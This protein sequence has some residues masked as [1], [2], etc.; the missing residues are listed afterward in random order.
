MKQFSVSASQIN[1]QSILLEKIEI[2]GAKAT[3]F[4]GTRQVNATTLDRQVRLARPGAIA[5]QSGGKPL[6]TTALSIHA[7]SMRQS[8]GGCWFTRDGMINEQHGIRWP[9]PYH[10]LTVMSRFADGAWLTALIRQ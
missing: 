1:H 8:S 6:G 4:T 5:P 9:I 2:S 3:A 7:S 10:D